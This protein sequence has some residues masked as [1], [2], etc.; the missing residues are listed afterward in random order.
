[1][2]FTKDDLRIEEREFSI[3]YE[4][5]RRLARRLKAGDSKTP[6][7]P[8]SLVH[9]ALL[10]LIESPSYEPASVAHVKYTAIRAMRHVLVDAAVR[11]KAEKRGGGIPPMDIEF[12]GMMAATGVDPDEVLAVNLALEKLE[13]SDEMLARIFECHHYG[14]FTQAEIAQIVGIPEKKVGKMLALAK[15]R[16]AQELAQPRAAAAAGH[17]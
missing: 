10:R 5:L 13:Q 17:E 7:N 2:G 14:G 4:E 1:M 16:L 3:A 15:A 6:I 8:T 11:R 9:E 12:A